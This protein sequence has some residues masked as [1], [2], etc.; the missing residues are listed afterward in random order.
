MASILC[1]TPGIGKTELMKYA[2]EHF[3]HSIQFLEFDSSLFHP[4][5]LLS[6]GHP[7]RDWPYNYVDI[8]FDAALSLNDEDTVILCSTHS[9][10]LEYLLHKKR[11]TKLNDRYININIVCDKPLEGFNIKVVQGKLDYIDHLK[12]IK[13]YFGKDLNSICF[14]DG[15]FKDFAYSF[16]SK[17]T[18]CR[19]INIMH[20]GSGVE[21]SSK[22]NV[23][24][25]YNVE[26]ITNVIEVID[27]DFEQGP[28][29]FKY[30]IK[31]L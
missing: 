4:Y 1:A 3:W 28:I 20:D 10:V 31:P 21:G 12:K 29:D 13:S 18:N 22:C 2:R 11:S 24:F 17:F 5:L 8:I 23:D 14:I 25:G 27:G 15:S 9:E 16:Y 6:G 26:S 19:T 7:E 30:I